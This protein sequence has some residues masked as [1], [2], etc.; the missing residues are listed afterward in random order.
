MTQECANHDELIQEYL[1]VLKYER[2]LSI[3]TVN[4]YSRQLYQIKHDLNIEDWLN[5]D[6]SAAKKVLSMGRKRG[7]SA[8]SI[9]LQISVLRSFFRYLL[10]DNRVKMNPI[11]AIGNVKE[12]KP[13]P[14]HLN[15]DEASTL[16]NFDV[17]DF[18]TSR[19]KCM[20]ELLYGCG[21]RLSELTA[22]N[23]DNIIEKTTIKVLGKGNKE[24]ML[25][26]GQKAQAALDEYIHKR[27][28]HLKDSYEPALFVSQR[29]SRI[30]NRQVANRLKQH[31]QQ[32]TLYQNISPHTLRHSFATHV[33]ESSKDL[34]GVQELLGH[35]N[36]STTQVYTHLNFQH[37]TEVYDKAHPRSKKK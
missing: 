13:L 35:A 25:P 34:R 37:L 5:F 8:R 22:L 21:L 19:D 16:L 2:Q 24:R 17:N 20:L 29:G 31:A 6:A 11:D 27:N 28:E 9:N 30:S 7:L 14:V 12:N 33:L 15:V 1:H 3:H 26:I 10:I 4:N 23:T 36:L 18:L 32:Q